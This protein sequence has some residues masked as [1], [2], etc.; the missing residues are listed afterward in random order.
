M[1]LETT[2]HSVHVKKYFKNSKNSMSL[3]F[4]NRKST[5]LKIDYPLITIR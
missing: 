2:L 3:Y 5:N 1:V 4:L